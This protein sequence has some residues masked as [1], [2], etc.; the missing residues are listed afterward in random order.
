MILQHSCSESINERERAVGCICVIF[1]EILRPWY[2]YNMY[3]HARKC[4]H[5]LDAER[6]RNVHVKKLVLYVTRLM[7]VLYVTRLM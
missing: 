2:A 1:V 5:V 7:Y 3:T 6:N 4:F